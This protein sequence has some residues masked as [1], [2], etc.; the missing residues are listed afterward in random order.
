[1][2]AAR[3][4]RVVRH[5]ANPEPLWTIQDGRTEVVAASEGDVLIR[6][7][8]ALSLVDLETGAAEWEL[9]GGWGRPVVAPDGTMF[10]GNRE[11]GIVCLESDGSPRWTHRG[12][13]GGLALGTDGTVWVGDAKNKVVGLDPK[14]GEPIRELRRCRK[15]LGVDWSWKLGCSPATGPDGTVYLTQAFDLVAADADGSRRWKKVL[16]TCYLED[17]QFLQDGTCLILTNDGLVQALSPTDGS[18]QWTA[19]LPRD[20]SYGEAPGDS[21]MVLEGQKIV[22]VSLE[23]H[24]FGVDSGTGRVTWTREPPAGIPTDEYGRAN[25]D[26]RPRLSVDGRGGLWVDE[27]ES[28]RMI[29]LDPDTGAELEVAQPAGRGWQHAMALPGSTELVA[30]SDG[31]RMA[32]FAKDPSL[33]GET[34]RTETVAASTVEVQEDYVD[35][36]SFRIGTRTD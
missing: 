5:E 30:L 28:S 31:S 7:S 15:V 17:P 6:S 1:M 2:D 22:G 12:T 34:L 26:S 20:R 3:A 29:R 9:P 33:L 10:V 24:V 25:W 4:M 27:R 14:T 16:D 23:G 8:G 36:Q 21:L 11:Q 35:I 19:M 13:G 18:V 32:V